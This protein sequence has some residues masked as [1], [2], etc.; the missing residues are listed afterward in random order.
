[1]TGLIFVEWLIRTLDVF[2]IES[3]VFS[4]GSLAV[5]SFSFGD[6]DQITAIVVYE[7]INTGRSSAT[8][9]NSPLLTLNENMKH[10][11]P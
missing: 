8:V 9:I 10:R 3:E 4:C 6:E 7:L 2:V 11:S 1:M 5:M